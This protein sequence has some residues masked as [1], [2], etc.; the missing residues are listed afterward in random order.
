[1]NRKSPEGT[2]PPFPPRT[3]QPQ[4]APTPN[5]FYFSATQCVLLWLHWHCKVAHKSLNFWNPCHM[6]VMM[7]Y[8]SWQS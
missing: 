1:M 6:Y 5:P 4:P 3:P 2:V 8:A 7:I